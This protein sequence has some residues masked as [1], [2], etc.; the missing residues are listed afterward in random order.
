MTASTGRGGMIRKIRLVIPA[1][2][3]ARA[4]KEEEKTCEIRM[5]GAERDLEKGI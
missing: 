3:P 4:K 1:F 2:Y 5:K